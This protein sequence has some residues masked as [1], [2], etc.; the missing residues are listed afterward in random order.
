V[1]NVG[2]NVHWTPEE[3]VKLNSA[4]MNTCKKK[5]GKEYRIDWA[6]VATLVPGRLETLCRNRWRDVLN[7]IIDR[8]N[9]H[10][11]KWTDDEDIKLKDAVQTHVGKDW[12]SIAALVPGRT[13]HQCC[14]RWHDALNSSIDRASG[15]KG[16]WTKDEDSKLKDAVQMH[17]GKNWA[18]TAALVLGRTKN[19][20]SKRWHD[21]LDS[22]VD[23]GTVRSGKWTEDEI[24]KLK[25]AVQ[26]H[27]GKN[28]DAIASL[29]PGRTKN[30][31]CKRWHNILHPCIDRRGKKYLRVHGHE[32]C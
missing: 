9:K 25:D 7:P 11:G 4:V 24:N 14:Q 19:Q 1:K 29:V 16:I 26:A 3:D 17:G 28:W 23:Q 5:H 22:S 20:C 13:R 27:G 32:M 10:M 18:A 30:Q 15:R 6:A 8:T 12:G 21:F 2:A 31:C